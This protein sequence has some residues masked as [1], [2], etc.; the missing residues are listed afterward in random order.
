[1]VDSTSEVP[2]IRQVMEEAKERLKGIWQSAETMTSEEW[3]CPSEVYWP[4][5]VERAIPSAVDPAL[6]AGVLK[7]CQEAR[8][9]IVLAGPCG[10]GKSCLA[11]MLASQVP[12]WRFISAA[13]LLGSLMTART[14][15]TKTVAMRTMTGKI[16]ERTESEI[17]RWIEEASML[18]L[19]DVGLRAETEA[20]AEAFLEVMNKPDMRPIMEFLDKKDGAGF[21]DIIEGHGRGRGCDICKPAVAS[22]LASLLNHHVLDGANATLQDTNDAYLANLQKNGTYSVVP[23]IPG[24]EITPEIGRAHV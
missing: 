18:V 24:G 14:A 23:R 16:V 1:M 17:W 8:W 11:A 2:R 6:L 13:G 19:D 10:T 5:G 21:D 15:E 9:P 20:R 4:E 3:T 7:A 12:Y 22:I